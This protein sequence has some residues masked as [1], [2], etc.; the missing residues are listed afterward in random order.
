L[1]RKRRHARLDTN[2]VMSTSKQYSVACTAHQFLAR[3]IGQ[4]MREREVLEE[5]VR[6]LR[7]AVQ[8]WTAVVEQTALPAVPDPPPDPV[9]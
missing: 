3:R 2:R 5:E 9:Q 4:L 7:A 8:I 1:R 6:Q